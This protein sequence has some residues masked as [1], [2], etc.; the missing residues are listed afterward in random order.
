MPQL[1]PSWWLGEGFVRPGSGPELPGYLMAWKRGLSGLQVKTGC[2]VGK[3]PCCGIPHHDAAPASVAHGTPARLSCS[4]SNKPRCFPTPGPLY[5]LS[6]VLKMLFL[7]TFHLALS[8]SSF[9]PQLQCL[10]FQEGLPD[11]RESKLGPLFFSPSKPSEQLSY[12][13]TRYVY[14]LHVCLPHRKVKPRPI[15]SSSHCIP[16]TYK[17]LKKKKKKVLSKCGWI[18]MVSSFKIMTSLLLN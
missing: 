8:F 3:S 2:F 12:F 5:V 6:L 10:V 17:V 11:H 18:V 4:F 7:L 9:R 13:I 15:Y 1:L 16:S 14:M